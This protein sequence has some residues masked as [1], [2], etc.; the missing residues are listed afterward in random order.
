MKFW[1]LALKT[2][3]LKHYHDK[4]QHIMSLE[5]R[6]EYSPEKSITGRIVKFGNF[7]DILE[8]NVDM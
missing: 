7:V 6:I 2:K 1:T 8:S 3:Y 5:C 4:E